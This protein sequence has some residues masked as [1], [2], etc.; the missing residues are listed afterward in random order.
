MFQ[1]Y[2]SHSPLLMYNCY[3]CLLLSKHI[4]VFFADYDMLY[5]HVCMCVRV[6]VFGVETLNFIYIVILH[7]YTVVLY[8]VLYV[9]ARYFHTLL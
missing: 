9:C 6:H 2:T 8:P 4:V 1:S 5:L 3:K 7:A